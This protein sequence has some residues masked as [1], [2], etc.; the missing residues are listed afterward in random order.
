MPKRKQSKDDDLRRVIAQTNESKEGYG[1]VVFEIFA[2][3]GMVGAHFGSWIVFAVVLV[4]LA[5][6]MFVPPLM[7]P[8]MVAFSVGWGVLGWAVGQALH[9][10]S[11]SVVIALI[12]FG[13]ALVGNFR[14]IEYMKAMSDEE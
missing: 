11:A 6:L 3:A 8:L 13:G 1:V 5:V 7:K 10:T 4:L 9:S 14:A 12:F 2:L